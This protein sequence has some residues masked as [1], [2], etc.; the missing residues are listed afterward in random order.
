ML[1]LIVVTTGGGVTGVDT[2]TGVTGGV[3]VDG[4][5]R[6][7]GPDHS[8]LDRMSDLVFLVSGTPVVPP[9]T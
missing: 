6:V 1:C 9:A 7:A 4:P 8:A 5:R 3:T 2:K